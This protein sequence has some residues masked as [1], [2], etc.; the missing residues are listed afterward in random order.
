MFTEVPVPSRVLV[1]A[2]PT[3]K[4]SRESMISDNLASVAVKDPYEPELGSVASPKEVEEGPTPEP[5]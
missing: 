1:E 4:P 5:S 2:V 3:G